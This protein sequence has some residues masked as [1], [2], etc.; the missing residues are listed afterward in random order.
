MAA[1]RKVWNCGDFLPY[2][3]IKLDEKKGQVPVGLPDEKYFVELNK[4][5]PDERFRYLKMMKAPDRHLYN[6]E[7][8]KLRY[9]V[10]N[11]FIL[12]GD[13]INTEREPDEK[14]E[15]EVMAIK[16]LPKYNLMR[17]GR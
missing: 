8:R 9:I 2:L 17:F 16:F 1:L 13:Q 5:K 12:N 14:G 11:K 10:G 15:T 4:G 3:R 6:L 7:P